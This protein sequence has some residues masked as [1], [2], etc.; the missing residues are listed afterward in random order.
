MICGKCSI[1][2]DKGQAP[3][4]T[5]CKKE[6]FSV[7]E[8]V[9]F[10]RI[11]RAESKSILL[12]C[13]KLELFNNQNIKYQYFGGISEIFQKNL[14]CWIL[15][16]LQALWSAVA[17][18]SSNPLFFFFLELCRG[19]MILL[20]SLRGRTRIIREYGKFYGRFSLITE[21]TNTKSVFFTTKH[22]NLERMSSIAFNT[23]PPLTFVSKEGSEKGWTK[24]ILLLLCIFCAALSLLV[25]VFINFPPFTQ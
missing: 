16:L 11:W 23:T 17:K 5:S 22:V 7:E 15:V 10:S 13:L 3:F 14:D 25:F 6:S 1:K 24:N 8:L 4:P 2:N 9:G 18:R 19:K 20:F 21:Q 12:F